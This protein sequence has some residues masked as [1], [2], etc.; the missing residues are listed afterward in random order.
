MASNTVRGATAAAGGGVAA[1]LLGYL[2][3]YILAGPSIQESDLNQIIEAVGEGNV[4]WKL[5]GWVFYNA[6][7]VT[8]TVDID[9]PFIGGTDVVNFIAQG[10]GLSP[11]LY[12]IPP[13]LLFGAG[14]LGVSIAGMTDLG[15]ALTIGPA[16]TIGYLPLAVA[17]AML[18][19]VSVGSSS[20]APTLVTAVGL[21]G[22][23]YPLLF[24]TAGAAIGVVL[25]G[26][27]GRQ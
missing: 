7:G 20:G 12:M 23:V 21:A 2:F 15:D 1:Y 6:H 5:V 18:F 3:T 24:G 27:N 11:V 16:V 19:S 4:A 14:L 17:G 10:D 8:T 26:R 9:A 22:L 13:A 25:A